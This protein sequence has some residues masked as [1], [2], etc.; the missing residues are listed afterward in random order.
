MVLLH[1]VVETDC[2]LAV[3]LMVYSIKEKNSPVVR[4]LLLHERI[5]STDQG[6]IEV[7]EL[8]TV[9]CQ[10]QGAVLDYREQNRLNFPT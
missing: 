8:L 1:E 7:G 4:K 2:D 5:D 6:S 10:R 9:A 3:R